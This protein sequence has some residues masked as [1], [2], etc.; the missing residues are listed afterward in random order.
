MSLGAM[1]SDSTFGLD[2]LILNR[3]PSG[4]ITTAW[5]NLGLWDD[6][7][8]YPDAARA[9][10]LR[11]GDA[12]ALGAGQRVLDVGF[13]LGEQLKL[14]LTHYGVDSVVGLNP[15]TLQVSY[16]KDMLMR[17][18]LAERITLEAKGARAICELPAQSFERIL[19][20]DSAYHFD[21]RERFINEST[22]VLKPGGRLGLIDIV[23]TTRALSGPRQ[24]ITPLLAKLMRV[25][26]ANLYDTREY[27]AILASTPHSDFTLEDISELIFPGFA[28]HIHRHPSA[29]GKAWRKMRL[30]ASILMRLYET[31]SIRALLVT[32]TR[33]KASTLR[34]I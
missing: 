3:S 20:L 9:L 28:N 11:L 12:L 29:R 4:H 13:G 34:V 23:P 7:A 22:R 31:G 25:P 8:S 19:A 1:T 6:A 30:T 26:R 21:T 24:L 14:W 33:W 27:E 15:S 17:A 32:L 18:N 2:E 10:A 16:A 5:A